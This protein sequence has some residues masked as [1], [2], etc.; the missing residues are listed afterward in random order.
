MFLF[1]VA[2][3][4]AAHSAALHDVKEARRALTKNPQ[5][6]VA[7]G[8]LREAKAHLRQL[9]A[10]RN[11][12]HAG[13]FPLSL[14]PSCFV[15]KGHLRRLQNSPTDTT[16]SRTTLTP[17][18]KSS[19][20]LIESV[21][22]SALLATSPCTDPTPIRRPPL[23]RSPRPLVAGKAQG[24]GRQASRRANSSPSR[25]SASPSR[26]SQATAG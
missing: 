2:Q 12:H 18:R 14:P 7:R 5:D 15:P 26:S 25:S 22:T 8:K 9:D 16:A 3:Q 24:G 19:L 11:A 4:K 23:R 10:E 21:R 13:P 6:P 1:T 20:K 17:A